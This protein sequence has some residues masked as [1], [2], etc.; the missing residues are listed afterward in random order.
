VARG[1]PIALTAQSYAMVE[2]AR[3]ISTNRAIRSMGALSGQTMNEIEDLLR[4]L[5]NL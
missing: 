4:Y 3:A 1:D 5:F 2:Q